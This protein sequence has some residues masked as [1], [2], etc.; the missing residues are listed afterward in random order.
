MLTRIKKFTGLRRVITADRVER[1]DGTMNTS[2]AGFNTRPK[3][4]AL[5]AAIAIILVAWTLPLH[6]QQVSTPRAGPPWSWRLIGTTEANF[7]ADHDG[8]IVQGPFNDFRRVKLKVTN[9]PLNMQRMVI[10]YDS[11]VPEN[12][13]VRSSIPEGGE[14]R[15]IDLAVVG[16]RRIRRIDFWYDTKGF[17]KG[18]AHVTVFGMK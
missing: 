14:S 16:K 15:Q 9:A 3:E 1:M 18:K 7:R 2:R 8:I 5:A 12:I 13:E 17:L 10:T 4:R 6:A 11:G